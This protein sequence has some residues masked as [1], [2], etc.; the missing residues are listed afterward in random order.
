MIEPQSQRLNRIRSFAVTVNGRLFRNNVGEAWAGKSKW[1][2]PLK[3]ILQ[4]INPSRIKYGLTV[5][6]SDL[7]GWK[8]VTVTQDMVGTNI[9]VFWAVEE[10]TGKD[11]LSEEQ[12][13]F[14]NQVVLFGGI[15]EIANSQNK[16]TT[17]TNV[18]TGE[19]YTILWGKDV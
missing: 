1:I 2:D 18:K 13:N 8:T 16:M 9:A 17:I 7:I 15:A 10:K 3:K 6:S 19:K 4:L 14:L 11:E 5:G 12:A